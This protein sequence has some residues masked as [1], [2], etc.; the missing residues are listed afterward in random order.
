MWKIS[1]LDTK[2]VDNLL[3]D[4]EEF[5]DAIDEMEHGIGINKSM[6][7]WANINFSSSFGDSGEFEGRVPV[8]QLSKCDECE[9]NSKTIDKQM[10]ILSK[11][12][13][14]LQV[15]QDKLKESKKLNKILEIKLEDAL[16]RLRQLNV[17]K[18]NVEKIGITIKCRECDFTCE[19]E[20]SLK[21]HKRE[22]KAKSRSEASAQKHEAEEGPLAEEES[23]CDK[24]N[25]KNKNRVLLGEHK[26]QVHK[27]L[28]CQFCGNVSPNEENFKVHS[29]VHGA[30]LKKGSQPNYPGNSL[31]FKCTPCKISFRSD[32]QLMN[33]MSMEHLTESQREGHGLYKYES[34]HE[35][36]IRDRPAPCKNGD[37]CRFHSQYRC[38]FYHERPPQVRQARPRRQAPSD[39][40][41]TVPPRWHHNNKEQIVHQSQDVQAL[42]PWC[43]YGSR[44]KLG[45]PGSWNQCL[46]RHE[47]EDFPS[48]PLQGRK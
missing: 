38:M 4:E 44:C 35:S 18:F 24:C 3:A 13:K 30:E 48:L 1:N 45:R 27:N 5:Y 8:V 21:E 2:E 41:L 19:S 25:Y 16:K 9:T 39:Q 26:E 28:V 7:D 12:D 42:P 33:H 46:L 17:E 15:S 32:D 20:E 31:N 29:M 6:I 22:A 10:E 40:W 11:N 36:N 23:K 34:Y 14:Q 43:V 47:G 37:Q